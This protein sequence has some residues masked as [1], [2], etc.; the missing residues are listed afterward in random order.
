LASPNDYLASLS[1]EEAKG[2]RAVL[3]P[4]YRRSFRIIFI[5]CAA[6]AGTAFVLAWFLMPQVSLNRDRK[7]DDKKE[8]STSDASVDHGNQEAPK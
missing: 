5:V 2:I 3:V 1:E 7:V 8:S 6:M 4:A